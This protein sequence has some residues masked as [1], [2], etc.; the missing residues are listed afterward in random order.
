M[1]GKAKSAAEWVP[2][3]DDKEI[4]I[5]RA[6]CGDPQ[7]PRI[8]GL[9]PCDDAHQDKF[10]LDIKEKM[11]DILFWGGNGYSRWV[12]CLRCGVRL[13][14]WPK[15]G[16]V[17][18]FRRSVNP[19]VVKEALEELMSEGK[20]ESASGTDVKAKIS[21]IEGRLADMKSTTKAAPQAKNKKKE[22]KAKTVQAQADRAAKT[23]E[24][25]K[26]ACAQ[27]KIGQP[28]GVDE[29]KGETQSETQPA[30]VDE[31]RDETQSETSTDSEKSAVMVMVQ[32]L[33]ELDKKVTGLV[34]ESKA[35]QRRVRQ[36]ERAVGTSKAD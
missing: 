8:A 4:D 32:E 35:I 27:P 2:P 6:V 11:P 7:D 10:N 1:G 17:G 5:L 16:W 34:H 36:L 12:D 13:G 19:E 15:A 26:A 24:K 3:C 14:F 28:A 22:D 18:K 31:T 33:D 21:Q 29:A 9:G 23:A 25:A 20:W 30:G